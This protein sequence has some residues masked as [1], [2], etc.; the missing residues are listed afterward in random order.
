M[1]KRLTPKGFIVEYNK[2][3]DFYT[4]RYGKCMK[5]CPLF[6][7]NE[8]K[9][10][11]KVICLNNI[12][13]NPGYIDEV[14]RRLIKN[15]E[16]R[17]RLQIENK[18][19]FTGESKIVNDHERGNV[20]LHRIVANKDIHVVISDLFATKIRKGEKGGW[21]ENVTNLS[22]HGNCWIHEEAM[23]FGNATVADNAYVT[24]KAKVCD[25]V[26]VCNNAYVRDNVRLFGNAMVYGFSVLS[27]NAFVFG[28]VTISGN[29]EI[30]RN[31]KVYDKAK[32]YNSRIKGNAVIKDFASVLD[33]AIITDNTFI[34]DNAIISGK[35][36]VK[37]K[38]EIGKNIKVEGIS[39]CSS[40][41]LII[42]KNFK[43]DLLGLS[44]LDTE[45][46]NNHYI[47]S[48]SAVNGNILVK[49]YMDDYDEDD[50]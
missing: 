12:I 8:V 35:V 10:P 22:Q 33:G 1:E 3:C 5:G 37:D 44:N 15:K 21:I 38:V 4:K 32:I 28:D 23:V 20:I 39:K 45:Y 6:D 34:H 40:D 7:M 47:V 41:Y 46:P 29:S 26:Q 50:Y 24:G 13:S 36:I 25:N 11:Y 18:Y 43:L 30:L 9:Y 14:E 17:K 27:D 2:L 19:T 31:A 42:D 16:E 48:N 49:F